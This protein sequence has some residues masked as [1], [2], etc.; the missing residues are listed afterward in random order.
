MTRQRRTIG[1][2]ADLERLKI[3]H[4]GEKQPLTFSD[5]EMERRLSGLRKIMAEEG[6]DVVLL[7]AYH[8]VKYYSA[9]LDTSFGRP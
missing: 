1:S 2:V 9:F 7:T 4:N 6:L 5:E 3:I 8:N